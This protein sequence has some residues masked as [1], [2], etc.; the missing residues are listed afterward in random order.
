MLLHRTLQQRFRYAATAAALSVLTISSGTIVAQDAQRQAAARVARERVAAEE[1]ANTTPGRSEN[2]EA[3]RPTPADQERLN[4]RAGE[5]TGAGTLG[6]SQI[7][8]MSVNE[9]GHGGVRV[10][11]VAASSPAF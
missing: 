9:V 11:D 6:E 3:A 7:L 8:G 10:V 4:R 5:R 2:T 1:R